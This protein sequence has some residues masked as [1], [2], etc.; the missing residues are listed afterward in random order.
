MST[1][2]N[3]REQVNKR[4]ASKQIIRIVGGADGHFKTFDNGKVQDGG[5]QAYPFLLGYDVW[6]IRARSVDVPELDAERDFYPSLRN[7]FTVD[8]TFYCPAKDFNTLGLGLDDLIEAYIQTVLAVTAIDNMA[9]RL[10]TQRGRF[11]QRFFGLINS[12]PALAAEVCS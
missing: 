4:A 7:A 3:V 9:K 10:V 11:R 6:E 12:D 1:I 8:G 2:T 5:G